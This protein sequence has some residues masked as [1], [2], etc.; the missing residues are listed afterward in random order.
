MLLCLLAGCAADTSPERAASLA[1][2]IANGSADAGHPS[3]GA[4]RTPAGAL[5]TATLVGR[6]TLLSA[7]HC[8][9]LFGREAAAFQLG[10]GSY[11]VVAAT[12]HP[13]FDFATGANDLAVL[14]LDRAPAEAPL[15]VSSQPPS[16]FDQVV[17]V[18]FGR[19]EESAIDSQGIK[20]QATNRV[21]WKTATTF[22]YFT[23]WGGSGTICPGDSGGPALLHLADRDVV[24]GVHST[25]GIDTA[26][27]RD[28]GILRSC[29]TAG[30][31]VRTDAYLP[32]IRQVAG[33]D[34]GIDEAVPAPPAEEQASVGTSA[35]AALGSATT[36]ARAPVRIVAPASGSVV[37]GGRVQ[38]QVWIDDA[39][40]AT[41]AELL[42]NGAAAQALNAPPFAFPATLAP[43][44]ATLEVRAFGPD[45]RVSSA[46]VQVEVVGAI[47]APA[48]AVAAAS[49][50]I[51]GPVNVAGSP[52]EEGGCA[53]GGAPPLRLSEALLALLWLAGLRLRALAARSHR[54]KAA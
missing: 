44:R 51:G 36:A 29:S 50:G 39:F 2:A 5:C 12:M 21:L 17:L 28:L 14:T 4:L 33:G 7:A 41:R 35:G 16:L 1:Q 49:A 6:R 23:T 43:G 38:V 9:Q 46:V 10:R 48:A 27:T 18:G 22:G 25:Y 31:D 47:G 24:V 8:V 3:V 19:T 20:R 30:F 26:L 13:D 32:W 45:G 53:L 40:A 52:A 11:A 15:A 34:V 37:A 42:V 54:R